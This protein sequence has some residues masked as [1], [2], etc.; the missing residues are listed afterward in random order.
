MGDLREAINGNIR[1]ELA[2]R[3]V[4][5]RQ[6]AEDMGRSPAWVRRRLN[7]HV[8]W[9]VDDLVWIASTYDLDLGLLIPEQ[10]S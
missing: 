7:G 8:P 1:A 3:R 6:L 4:S 10:V 2:R 9:D 5:G